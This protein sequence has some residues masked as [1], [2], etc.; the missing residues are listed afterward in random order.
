MLDA[1]VDTSHDEQIQEDRLGQEYWY[2]IYNSDFSTESLRD[3]YL[4]KR[5]FWNVI[6]LDSERSNYHKIV[7]FG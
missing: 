2:K 1:S 5:Q 4:C 6:I 3:S 7:T